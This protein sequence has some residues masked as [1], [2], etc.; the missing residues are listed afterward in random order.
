MSF[1]VGQIWNRVCEGCRGR[2]GCS[3]FLGLLLFLYKNVHSPSFL[4]PSCPGLNVPE[5]YA[6]DLLPS[7]V[8]L[9]LLDKPAKPLGFSYGL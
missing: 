9:C 5:H 1:L 2:L 7:L 4:L 8:L 3:P 6:S